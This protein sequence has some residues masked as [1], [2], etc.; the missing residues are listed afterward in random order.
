MAKAQKDSAEDIETAKRIVRMCRLGF[1]ICIVIAVLLF[2]GLP[3]SWLRWAAVGAFLAMAIGI[4]FFQASSEE[5]LRKIV[6]E[7]KSNR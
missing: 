6:E 2:F 5:E 1:R 4:G 3:H 7:A